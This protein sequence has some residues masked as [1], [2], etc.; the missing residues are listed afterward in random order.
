MFLEPKVWVPYYSFVLTTIAIEYPETANEITRKKYYEL[1]SNLP[2]FMPKGE[3]S[4][5]FIKMLDQYPV[6]PYLDTRHSFMK[7]THFIQNKIY[8]LCDLPEKTTA[9]SMQEYYD[10]YKP[11]E[12]IMKEHYKKKEKYLFGVAIVLLILSGLYL[13]RK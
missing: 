7:W 5:A 3:I 12:V 11:K 4:R 6:S 9:E 8:E 2:I 10:L 13:Y 1:I